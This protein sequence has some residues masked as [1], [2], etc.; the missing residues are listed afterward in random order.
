MLL[1][2]SSPTNNEYAPPGMPTFFA[3]KEHRILCLL[4][5]KL[6]TNQ[7]LHLILHLILRLHWA[8][9][10][11]NNNTTTIGTTNTT[12]T[13]TNNTTVTEQTTLQ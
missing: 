13:G 7:I 4:M 2:S 12:I 11:N 10:D 6:I 1:A 9:N 3:D 5:I 8:T